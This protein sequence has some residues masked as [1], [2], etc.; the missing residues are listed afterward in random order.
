MTSPT[1]TGGG[2][3]GWRPIETFKRDIGHRPA[4]VGKRGTKYMAMA[5]YLG[6]RFVWADSLIPV[7]FKPDC[8]QPLPEPPN[9]PGAG[10]RGVDDER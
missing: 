5:L 4:I 6:G 9:H 8:F 10:R 2:L 1:P 7:C 3:A